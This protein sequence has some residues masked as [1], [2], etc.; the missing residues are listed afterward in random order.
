MRFSSRSDR[1]PLRPVA[2]RAR[3][4][5]FTLAEVVV[6]MVILSVGL[7]ALASGSMGVIRQMRSGNQAAIAAMVA[8]SRMEKMRS[9]TCSSITTG[10]ATTSGMAEKWSVNAMSARIS[11]VT[12]TVTYV[13]RPG[14]TKKLGMTG[15]V[16]CT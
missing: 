11:A 12:E 8:Q 1:A 3:R 14:V 16:P 6:A 13:P 7:L 9:R 15:V 4:D 10:T 2:A 5:G